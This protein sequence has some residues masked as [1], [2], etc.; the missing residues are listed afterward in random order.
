MNNCVPKS[1]YERLENKLTSVHHCRCIDGKI[2]G[3]GSCVGYCKFKDHPG[4]LTAELRKVHNCLI[5]G[6]HYYLAKERTAKDKAVSVE[7]AVLQIALECAN[8]IPWLRVM[9][10]RNVGGVVTVFYIAVSDDCPI[11]LL[12]HCISEQS[13]EQVCLKRIECGYE[14]AVLLVCEK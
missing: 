3:R 11:S 2:T 1:E 4:F 10:V 6:C 13:G 9:N 14:D 7:E 5:K 8:S 12:E